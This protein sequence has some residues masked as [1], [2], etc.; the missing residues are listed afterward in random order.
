MFE[1]LLDLVRGKKTTIGLVLSLINTYLL[2][3]GVYGN[4]ELV[5]I[6]GILLALGL[7]ANVA[8]NRLQIKRSE[9]TINNNQ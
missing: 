7:T 8:D 1:Q 3:I 2:T 9:E 4:N 5:L 6:S